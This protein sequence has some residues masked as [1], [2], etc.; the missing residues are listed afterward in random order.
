MHIK[1]FDPDTYATLEVETIHD[2]IRLGLQFPGIINKDTLDIL[3]ELSKQED[4]LFHKLLIINLKER[5]SEEMSNTLPVENLT[6]E[7]KEIL[8]THI[9]SKEIRLVFDHLYHTND[10]K[11]FK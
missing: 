8:F 2:A 5:F 7:E 3:K 10:G 4:D 1:K 9:L 11:T 6:P